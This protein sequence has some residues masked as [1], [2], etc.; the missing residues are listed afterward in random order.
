MIAFR[1]D[2]DTRRGLVDRVPP[3]LDLLDEHGIRATFFCV[4]GPEANLA[5]IV[6]LRFL[7]PREAKSPL[8][9]GAKGGVAK[10]A[11]AA[12]AP[13]KVGIGNPDRLRDIVA[14]GHE[15]QPH[16]WSHIQWQRNLDAIDV[17]EHL[18]R[19]IRTQETIVGAPV[20]GFASPGRSCNEDAL[21]AFDEAGLVYGGDLD[22]E[23]PFVPAGHD[24]LQIPITRFETIAQMRRRG[25]SDEQI[26]AS[27]LDHVDE[28]RQFTCLYEHPDDLDDAGLAIFG[29]VFRG[30][31]ERGLEPV[32]LSEVASAW[33]G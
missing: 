2:I 19:A 28:R 26:V 29:E 30:V 5:E 4:M 22:G 6:R 14:R 23:V 17:R 11:L 1:F 3:L 8:N 31:R 33:R 9:V 10:L 13:R 12:L 21:R 20:T 16:G 18:R 32:T 7:A 24:H 27:Y 15:L 25:L